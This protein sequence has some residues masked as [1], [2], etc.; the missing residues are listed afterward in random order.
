M[1]LMPVDSASYMNI[2]LELHPMLT[3][4]IVKPVAVIQ[5]SSRS[6]TIKPTRTT[7]IPSIFVLL[8]V[9]NLESTTVSENRSEKRRSRERFLFFISFVF[10]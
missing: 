10:T 8:F 2:L 1:M 3:P 7:D 9:M 5:K 6:E 4:P